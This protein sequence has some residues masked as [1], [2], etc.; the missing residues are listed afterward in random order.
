MGLFFF[1]HDDGIVTIA[2]KYLVSLV[3]AV[4]L[5]HA[6]H[7]G[8]RLTRL[9]QADKLDGVDLVLRAQGLL[10]GLV[11]QRYPPVLGQR[12]RGVRELRALGAQVGGAHGAVHGGRVA[13][14]LVTADDALAEK[15]RAKKEVV[16]LGW[17][18]LVKKRET[19]AGLRW[20]EV[21]GG[22]ALLLPCPSG[23]PPPP[24]TGWWRRSGGAPEARAEQSS[25]SDPKLQNPLYGKKEGKKRSQILTW[26]QYKVYE[27]EKMNGFLTA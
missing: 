26:D 13:L 3:L 12:A 20:S 27:A 16:G 19:T 21:G 1:P 14:V 22:R 9:L 18:G 17:A 25:S 2:L 6:A 5:A 7:E 4:L 8:P 23:L 10:V 24:L 15:G 11:G